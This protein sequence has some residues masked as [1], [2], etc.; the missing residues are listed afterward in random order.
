LPAQFQENLKNGKPIKL[1]GKELTNEESLRRV[2][3]I[4][5]EI[6]QVTTQVS[7]LK[8]HQNALRTMKQQYENEFREFPI[9]LARLKADLEVV[10]TRVA[11]ERERLN[12]IEKNG[13]CP[14]LQKLFDN[15]KKSLDK[16]YL[17]YWRNSKEIEKYDFG[18]AE[19]SNEIDIEEKIL[20]N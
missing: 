17:Q 10:L 7:E 19:L 2:E 12:L 20:A 3:L 13:G 5:I 6:S 9:M 4:S 11:C 8:N 18:N 1:N 14:N 15:A 16:A